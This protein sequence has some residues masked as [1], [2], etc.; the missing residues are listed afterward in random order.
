MGKRQRSGHKRR[1]SRHR[2]HG[3]RH[4]R[5][6][7]SKSA[8]SRNSSVSPIS[9]RG[10]NRTTD[11]Q[12]AAESLNQFTQ[13]IT[14]L[15]RNTAAGV[16]N[17]GINGDCVPYFNPQG[18]NQ[19]AI[20]WCRKVDELR[21]VFNW[22]EQQT[23]FFA[24]A[25][26]K[27][28]AEVWYQ[29]LGTINYSWSEWKQQL[30]EAFPFK[31]EFDDLL[32]EM[33]GRRK[34]SDELYADYYHEKVALLN[35]CGIRGS[36][37]VSCV[38]GGIEDHVVKTGAKAGRH[39]TVESLFEFLSSFNSSSSTSQVATRPPQ[40]LTNK[41]RRFESW[42]NSKPS[43]SGAVCYKC[44]KRGHYANNC[45]AKASEKRCTHCNSK[46][47]GESVCPR[48]KEVKKPVA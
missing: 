8:V 29:G 18:V 38:I 37:A 22:T 31:K 27:G 36:N 45:E 48:R 39:A 43:S 30:Q 44:G 35:A 40:N 3:S 25:K 34:R 33:V 21:G 10:L 1:D 6:S 41:K 32:K 46:F 24:L 16:N 42:K 5:R 9:K 19:S 28:H 15:V 23:I 4:S 47:H 26:L 12:S 7:R 14:A 2:G 11:T 17:V 20:A 13:A